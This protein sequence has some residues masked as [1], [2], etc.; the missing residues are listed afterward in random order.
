MTESAG[1]LHAFLSGN[2]RDGRGRLVADVLG[3]SDHELERHHDFIQ[4]LFPL[5]VRS[6]AQP[7]APVLDDAQIAAIRDDPDATANLSRGSERMLRFYRDTDAWLCLADHNH[8]RITRIIR[9]LKLLVGLDAARAFYETILALHRDAGSPIN[10]A[11]LRFWKE[12]VAG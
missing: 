8:L 10:A 11:S 1:P 6:S 7:N 2:G 3:F 5:P 9:S 4:W 12:A